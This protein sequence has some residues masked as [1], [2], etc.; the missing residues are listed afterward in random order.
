[1]ETVIIKRS[2]KNIEAS[3]T[4]V[5][6]FML[7]IFFFEYINPIDKNRTSFFSTPLI[8]MNLL[9]VLPFLVLIMQL[10]NNLKPEIILTTNG[11]KFRDKKFY[12]WIE[13]IGYESKI[14]YR[15]V[16]KSPESE[17]F[18][19]EFNLFIIYFSD[20]TEK[21]FNVTELFPNKQAVEYLTLFDKYKINVDK[22]ERTTWILNA[23]N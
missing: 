1:M 20:S 9:W 22:S 3:F 8:Y 5:I 16:P 11:I 14:F 19:Y 17:E 4:A 15:T 7:P 21:N 23:D 6:I 13:V 10:F 2:R 12:K 18:I